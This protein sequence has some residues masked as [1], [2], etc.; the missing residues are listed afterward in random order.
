MQATV[1][2]PFPSC[3]PGTT[4]ATLSHLD[5]PAVFSEACEPSPN[6][7]SLKLLAVSYAWNYADLPAN[8]SVLVQM[9]APTVSDLPTGV[10]NLVF[11]KAASTAACWKCSWPAGAG[12]CFSTRPTLRR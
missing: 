6:D 11:F 9:D 10:Y 1:L 4:P 3:P 8:D 7:V 2:P 5:P 12:S